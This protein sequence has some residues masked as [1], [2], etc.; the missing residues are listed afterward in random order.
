MPR[1]DPPDVLHAG[2]P[3]A[4]PRHTLASTKE[5]R[6][7]DADPSSPPRAGVPDDT[8]ATH[9][10][11]K[12]W[13]LVAPAADPTTLPR[14]WVP[15]VTTSAPASTR[16]PRNEAATLDEAPTADGPLAADSRDEPAIDD[17]DTH[18]AVGIPDTAAAIEG[19]ESNAAAILADSERPGS[20]TAVDEEALDF[21]VLRVACG[22]SEEAGRPAPITR[23]VTGTAAPLPAAAPP[24]LPFPLIL[25]L[26]C[27]AMNAGPRAAKAPP[28][29]RRRPAHIPPVGELHAVG[30]VGD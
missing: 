15:D 1:V 11:P 24:A 2:V 20:A 19:G 9:S 18:I 28:V 21:A 30:G 5:S 23:S 13:S 12:Y 26:S 6:A 14:V 10:S 16:S 22:A 17:V 27:A 8:P 4:G 29:C 3:G 7:H 25:P